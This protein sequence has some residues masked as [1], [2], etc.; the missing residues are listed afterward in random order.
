MDG[1]NLT[2]TADIVRRWKKNCEELLNTTET[3]SIQEVELEQS[4]ESEPSS[5]AEVTGVVGQLLSGRAPEVDDIRLKMLKALDV[6]VMADI[7][8]QCCVEVRNTTKTN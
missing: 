6:V 3:A 8:P 7:N 4:G 1:E 2:L 5:V